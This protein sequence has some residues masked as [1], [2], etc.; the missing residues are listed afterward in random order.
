[1]DLILTGLICMTHLYSFYCLEPRFPR[2]HKKTTAGIAPCGRFV[3][4]KEFTFLPDLF[5]D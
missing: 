1:M 2:R 3:K 5:P 4:Q